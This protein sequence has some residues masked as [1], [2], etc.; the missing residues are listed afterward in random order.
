MEEITKKSKTKQKEESRM[1]DKLAEELV[2][3]SPSLLLKLSCE[4]EILIEIQKAQGMKSFGAKRRQL[5]YLSKLLRETPL[6]PLIN[7]LEHHK[8]SHLKQNKIFHDLEQIRNRIIFRDENENEDEV[9]NESALL[10]AKEKFPSLDI[11]AIRHLVAQYRWTRQQRYSREIFRQ[12]TIAQRH[13]EINN[14]QETLS[15]E[16]IKNKG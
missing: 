4:S 2:E 8:K 7:F 16:S 13:K 11:G 9:E 5:K 6:E 3:L 10:E 12:L 14:N 1:L 15:L